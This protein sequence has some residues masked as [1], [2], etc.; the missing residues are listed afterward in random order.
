MKQKTLHYLIVLAIA[1]IS[2]AGCKH[3]V[4]FKNLTLDSEV[5][6][7]LNNL[8]IGEMSATFNDLIGLVDA[9]NTTIAPDEDGV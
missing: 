2:M 1:G 9:K 7:L 3:D 5:N 6:V 4:D 8:P